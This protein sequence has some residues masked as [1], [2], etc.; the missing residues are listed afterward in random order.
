MNLIYTNRFQIGVKASVI[1]AILIIILV[2]F[3]VYRLTPAKGIKTITTEQL[4][5]MLYD[6]GKVFV[7]VRSPLEYKGQHIEQFQNIPLKSNFKDLPKD[8]E[9]VVICQTGIRS[10][11]ACKKLKRRG[12]AN[13]T[14]VRGGLSHWNFKGEK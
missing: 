2:A 13:V 11:Q 9:I 1:E 7:D 5:G 4:K 14:N 12:Y 6:P 8:K 10:N 3:I